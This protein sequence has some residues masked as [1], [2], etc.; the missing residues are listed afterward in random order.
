MKIIINSNTVKFVYT[1][2][3][4]DRALLKVGLGK[5]KRLGDIIYDSSKGGWRIKFG[6]KFIER[7]FETYEDAVKAEVQI[8]ESI[9]GKETTHG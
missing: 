7:T 1:D 6:K 9:L 5:S 2:D 8:A 3:I 4:V